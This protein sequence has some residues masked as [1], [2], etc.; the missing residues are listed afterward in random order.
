MWG[1]RFVLMKIVNWTKMILWVC[2]NRYNNWF[3]FLVWLMVSQ[4][5]L[6]CSRFATFA[7]ERN[8]QYLKNVFLICLNFNITIPNCRKALKQRRKKGFAK[9]SDL[10]LV[11]LYILMQPLCFALHFLLLVIFHPEKETV[12]DNL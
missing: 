2:L 3:F 10:R 4:K 5:K 12:Y 8:I 9:E 11:E 6:N 1:H 7:I